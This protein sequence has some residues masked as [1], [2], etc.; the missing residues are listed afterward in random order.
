MVGKLVQDMAENSAWTEAWGLGS[1][2]VGLYVT[3]TSWQRGDWIS[4]SSILKET[5]QKPPLFR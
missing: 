1:F 5:R 3:W 2:H 4:R